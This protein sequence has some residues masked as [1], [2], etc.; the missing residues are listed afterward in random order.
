MV[1]EEI[2]RF[3][4]RVEKINLRK[5][6]ETEGDHFGIMKV[7][8]EILGLGPKEENDSIKK[9]EVFFFDNE[10]SER[11]DYFNLMLESKFLQINCSSLDE[12]NYNP[13]AEAA[14]FLK[15]HPEVKRIALGC[16]KL[17]EESSF[18]FCCHTKEMSIWHST[19]MT[20]DIQPGSCDVITDLRDPRFWE[21]IEPES[22]EEISDHTNHNDLLFT[23]LDTIKNIAKALVPNGK[24]TTV[25]GWN[26]EDLKEVLHQAGFKSEDN[27]HGRIWRKVSS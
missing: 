5:G 27:V 14:R 7:V 16:G 23:N 18:S 20:I 26:N 15:D 2:V 21:G 17:V 12:F 22:I 13:G 8:C 10:K 3:E 6:K 4:E 9:K 25:Y 1:K 24:L 11:Y 19:A